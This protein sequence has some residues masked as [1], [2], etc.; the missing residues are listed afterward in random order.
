M[1]FSAEQLKLKRRLDAIISS[2]E[3]DEVNRLRDNLLEKGVECAILVPLFEL[4]MDFD[5]IADVKYERKAADSTNHYLDF[6]L[7][8]KV[9]V[10]AKKFGLAFTKEIVEQITKYIALNDDINYGILTN[11]WEYAFFVQRHFMEK[12]FNDGE[13]LQ[14]HQKDVFPAMSISIDDEYFY[15][16]ISLFKKSVYESTFLSVAKCVYRELVKTQGKYPTITGAGKVDAFM[17]KRIEESVDFKPGE[18]HSDIQKQ[19]RSPGDMVLYEAKGV[20]IP[21]VIKGDGKLIVKQGTAEITDF[22]QVMQDQTFLPMIDLIRGEWSES[23]TEYDS[24]SDII[25]Q[26]TGMQKPHA[27]KFPFKFV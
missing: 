4:F 6:L 1:E 20:R 8:D 26:A 5:P 10:E 23:D 19:K 3:T 18:F 25:K 22:Q 17:K 11:G 7:D 14:G 15:D 13:R 21:A 12:R 16:V 2:Q 24:R 9:V 27:S